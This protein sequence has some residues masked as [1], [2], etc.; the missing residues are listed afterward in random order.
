V[1]AAAAVPVVARADRLTAKRVVKPDL[2]DAPIGLLDFHLE[3]SWVES[4]V[5]DV[6][7]PPPALTARSS[8]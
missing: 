4:L 5:T 1:R 2:D 8:P 3:P 6:A 7:V